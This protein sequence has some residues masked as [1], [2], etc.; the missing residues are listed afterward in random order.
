MTPSFIS[1]WTAE[2]AVDACVQ[3]GGENLTIFRLAWSQKAKQEEWRIMGVCLTQQQCH[4]A[5]IF[6]TVIVS[7]TPIFCNNF[8]GRKVSIKSPRFSTMTS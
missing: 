5:K 1:R 6:Q 2:E 7:S 4:N 8:D 3:K